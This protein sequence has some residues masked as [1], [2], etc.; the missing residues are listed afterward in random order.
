MS[1]SIFPLTAAHVFES[2]ETQLAPRNST[3]RPLL[4]ADTRQNRRRSQRKGFRKPI[5]VLRS[6]PVQG[7]RPREI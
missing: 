3:T 2:F 7:F 1:P 5:Q 4:T 6:V